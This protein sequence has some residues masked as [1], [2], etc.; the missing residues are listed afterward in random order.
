MRLTSVLAGGLVFLRPDE[1]AVGVLTIIS[2]RSILLMKTRETG[3]C[4][5]PSTTS[6]P[7]KYV[8]DPE[9]FLRRDFPVIE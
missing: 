8:H 5:A 4:L 6:A 7:D 1:L 2:L 3:V 9:I